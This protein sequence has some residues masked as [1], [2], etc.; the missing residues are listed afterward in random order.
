[1]KQI[2]PALKDSSFSEF[3]RNAT[4][5]EKERVYTDVMKRATERQ[6]LADARGHAYDS[7]CGCGACAQDR[8]ERDAGGPD[9]T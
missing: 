2:V 4:P 9:R 3:I 6:R 8:A 1:M 7:G 5:E